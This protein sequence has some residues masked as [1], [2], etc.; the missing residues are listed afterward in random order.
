MR[1][2][3]EISERARDERDMRDERESRGMRESRG[4]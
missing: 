1:D 2:L 3:R 4:R